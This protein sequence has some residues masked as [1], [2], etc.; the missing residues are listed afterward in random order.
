MST[1]DVKNARYNFLKL[2][3]PKYTIL[4]NTLI[5]AKICPLQLAATLLA[6]TKSGQPPLFCV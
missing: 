1:P 2:S 4:R 5:Y 6:L 3:N